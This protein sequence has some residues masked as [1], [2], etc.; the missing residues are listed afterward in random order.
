MVCSLERWHGETRVSPNFLRGL[1]LVA[2]GAIFWLIY[3]DLKD[4]LTKEPRRLLFYS[5]LLGGVS[6]GVALLLYKL[7]RFAGVTVGPDQPMTDVLLYTVA[8]VGPIEE[9]AKFLVARLVIFGWKDFDEPI[10]GLLYAACVAI[11]FAAVE[12]VLYL[13]DLP[14][15][16]QAAR[17]IVSPL[18]HSLFA[19][20][21][22][23]GAAK[24]ILHA[25][26]LPAKI[27]W[28]AA[29]LVTAMVLHGLYDF[30]LLAWNATI[31]VAL[32]TLVLW[33]GLIAYAAHVVHTKHPVITDAESG[34]IRPPT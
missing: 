33:L 5:F 30:L 4:R 12:N 7:V 29:P 32:G 8:I 14:L 24:A 3:F 25:K 22:G 19:A 17:A 23:F 18:T 2:C 28:F 26:T 13:P 34:E 27:F 10:D 9:G 15:H 31:P 6:V 1:A 21:W 20:L 16:E 11:G